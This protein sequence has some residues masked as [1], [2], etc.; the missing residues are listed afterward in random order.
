MKTKVVCRGG[1]LTGRQG[2][3]LGERSTGLTRLSAAT[4]AARERTAR[5]YG[6][7][8]GMGCIRTTAAN[9]FCE[10]HPLINARGL[11]VACANSHLQHHAT[12][13]QHGP[14]SRHPP[15]SLA[16]RRVTDAQ[17]RQTFYIISWPPSTRLPHTR[18]TRVC[19]RCRS[20]HHLAV[21]IF[22]R[23]MKRCRSPNCTAVSSSSHHAY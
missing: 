16:K 2:G 8:E 14:Q 20:S 7:F 3:C 18:D 19:Q 23:V 6:H 5:F 13:P 22:V 17:S 11:R 1:G 15:P 9:R 4:F 12:L 10:T 21:I